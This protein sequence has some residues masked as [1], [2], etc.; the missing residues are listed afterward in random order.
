M[1]MLMLVVLV[2]GCDSGDQDNAEPNQRNAL[3]G[4]WELRSTC[5]GLVKSL[6][7]AGLRAIA[8]S[9]AGDY[10]PSE[11]QYQLARKRDV[12]RGAEPQRHAQ[13]FTAE[14]EFGSLN[15]TG[16]KEGDNS[17]YRVV[18]ARTLRIAGPY[19]EYYRYRIEGGDRLTLE[20]I[21]PKEARRAARANPLEWGQAAHMASVAYAGHTWKRVDCGIWC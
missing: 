16:D 6:D 10:F 5:E 4:R 3:V 8:P 1:A 7:R 21:V 20:P 18:D 9:V 17:P 13:F 2:T 12:C 14:G 11:T 15:Q 19:R